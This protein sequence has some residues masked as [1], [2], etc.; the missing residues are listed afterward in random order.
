MTAL[1]E[2][3]GAVITVALVIITCIYAFSSYKRNVI[4]ADEYVLWEDVTEKSPYKARGYTYLGIAFAKEERFTEAFDKLRTAVSLRPGDIE[5][6]L[7]LGV[8]YLDTGNTE[9]AEGVFAD[10]IAIRPEVMEPYKLLARV[11]AESGRHGKTVRLMKKALARWPAEAGLVLIRA[12]ALAMAGNFGEAE[13]A[14]KRL[15]KANPGQGAA[16]T[17]LGNILLIE[18]KYEESILYYKVALKSNPDEPEPL[19]NIALALESLGRNDEALASYRKFIAR[20]SLT[21]EAFS[22][23]LKR[24]KERTRALSASP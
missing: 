10:L 11:Y 5:A 14:Y 2:R 18:G 15:L 16:L 19:F 13:V 21:P 6:R 8:L 7:N 12:E 3:S 22:E 24:A 20:A 23:A 1:R 4:W 9:L 17:G